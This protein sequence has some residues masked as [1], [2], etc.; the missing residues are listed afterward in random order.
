[1]GKPRRICEWRVQYHKEEKTNSKENEEEKG[2]GS[3]SFPPFSS[4]LR[5]RISN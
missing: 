3:I 2:K 5:R 4:K 1:M